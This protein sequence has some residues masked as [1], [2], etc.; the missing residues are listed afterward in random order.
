MI[1]VDFEIHTFTE[2][3]K[4]IYVISHDLPSEKKM[5]TY[6]NFKRKVSFRIKFSKVK[7][8]QSALRELLY[9]YSHEGSQ[10]INN[11]NGL[12]SEHLA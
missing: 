7:L 8:Q 1:K 3:L 12:I 9:T 2:K 5:I 10:I 11:Q 4:L 6:R